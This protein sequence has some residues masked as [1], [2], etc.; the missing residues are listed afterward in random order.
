[1]NWIDFV[2]LIVFLFFIFE[3]FRSGFWVIFIDFVSFLF[4]LLLALRLYPFAS[5]ILKENLEITRSV[6]NAIG[7][8]LIAILSEVV[9]GIALSRFLKKLPEH[10]RDFRYQKFIAILPALGEVLVLASFFLTL[11]LSFPVNPV[12]KSNIDKSLI[13][14]FLVRQTSGLESGLS[15]AFGGVVEDSLTRLIVKPGTNE[16]VPLEIDSLEL[17][18]DKDAEK[19]M[20]ELVNN[21]R[22]RV[23]REI[24]V[25]R[26][27][28]VPVANAHARDMWEK[29]YFGHVSPE[30]RDVGD[31]LEERRVE[32][33]VA[34]ENLAL[35]PTTDVAHTGLM[36]SEGHRANILS[37]DFE[38]IGIGVIDNGYYGKMFVQVFTN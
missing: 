8:L 23:G 5:T 28:L 10:I 35:S 33:L 37:E 19:R 20:F 13:G 30:G 3:S 14:G 4:S 9:I 18:E 31:R 15:G 16:T 36:N 24:L 2:I 12:L 21:E 38:S 34:G 27:E 25:W 17:R 26:E 29:G 6:S 32:Y 7:F 11:V 22:A 1:M